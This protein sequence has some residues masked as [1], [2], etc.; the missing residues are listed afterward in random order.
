MKKEELRMQM[1]AGIITE[2]QY[3]QKLNEST[4]PND[5]EVE[6]VYEMLKD[7][8]GE[9]MEIDMFPIDGEAGYEGEYDS[10]LK[11]SIDGGEFEVDKEEDK[12]HVYFMEEDGDYYF[13]RAENVVAFI[14]KEMNNLK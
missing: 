8:F 1:L 10:Y 11:I 4:H 9:E 12:F 5:S 7:E 14:Q 6:A 13:D 3:K 2:S